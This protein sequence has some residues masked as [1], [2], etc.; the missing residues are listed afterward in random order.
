MKFAYPRSN[1]AASH[2]R[3]DAT[4]AAALDLRDDCDLEYAHYYGTGANGSNDRIDG[5]SG[6]GVGGGV[7]GCWWWLLVVVVVVV[8]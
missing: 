3:K 5:V 6:G 4:A 2:G 7:G 8:W 1:T